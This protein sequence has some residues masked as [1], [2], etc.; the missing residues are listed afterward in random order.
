MI[1]DAAGKGMG[2]ALYMALIRTYAVAYHT[3]PDDVMYA[4]NQ[5]ILK[6]TRADPFMTVFYAVLD[7]ISGEMTY[8]NAGHNP[9]AGCSRI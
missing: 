4:A 1:A 7:P 3:R 5:R 2:A 8:C 6:D 9:P